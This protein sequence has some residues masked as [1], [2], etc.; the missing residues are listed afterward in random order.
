MPYD[1]MI[2]SSVLPNGRTAYY[3]QL[4][5]SAQP[6]FL[7]GYKTLYDGNNFGIYNTFVLPG[8]EVYDPAKF[9]AEFGF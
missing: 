8:Q 2:S 4:K 3:A 5:N 1:F 9:A 6:K 7:I